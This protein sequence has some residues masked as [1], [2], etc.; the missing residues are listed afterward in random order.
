VNGKI[1]LE[2][3]DF[4]CTKLLIAASVLLASGVD[5]AAETPRLAPIPLSSEAAR[6]ATKTGSLEVAEA[7]LSFLAGAAR[8]LHDRFGRYKEVDE[9]TLR[10]FVEHGMGA[11]PESSD[12]E[13]GENSAARAKRARKELSAEVHQRPMPTTD[14]SDYNRRESRAP[15][16]DANSALSRCVLQLLV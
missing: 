14:A 13:N 8:T 16:T 12:K 5:R 1:T 9:A 4:G 15:T 3:A 11:A 10:H 6:G 7:V 2:A